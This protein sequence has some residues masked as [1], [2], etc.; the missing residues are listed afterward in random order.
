MAISEGT[1]LWEPSAEW[2]KNANL[3]RYMDWLSEKKGLPFD[4]YTSLWQW[5]VTDLE[6]FWES[7]WE[8]FDIQSKTSYT[9]V[10]EDRR[11]PGAK[12]FVG[13]TLNYAE[14][15]F[16]HRREDETA[17][18]Y[19]SELR[20]LKSLTWRDLEEQVAAFAH[21]L[22]DLGVKKGDRVA[23][24]VANMPEA[25][26]AFLG[27]ASIGAI[28]SSCSPEFGAKSVIDRFKQIEPKVLVAVDGYR[29]NGKDFDRLDTVNAIQK[30]VPT[31]EKTIMIP[32]LHE[33]VSEHTV[34]NMV[35]WQVFLENQPKTQLY[36][37]A[38]PF[39]H[40]LWI[41]FSSG[42]TGI[43][44]AIV[45]GHGGILIEQ[46]KA[47]SLHTDL[48]PEDRFF[49]YTTT[50]WMMW[51]F[52]V[53]GL[54]TGAKIILYDGSP[55]YPDKNALWKLAENTGMTVFGTSAA[56]ITGCMKDQ[57]EPGRHY[58]LS[59]LKAI[60]STGSPLPPNGFQWVYDHVKKD[61]WLA[62]VSGGT[63][64]CSAF[65][66]GAP[67]LPVKTGMIQCRGLGAA[68]YAFDD[69]GKPVVDHVGELVMTEPL[70]SMPLFFWNDPNGSRYRNSYFDVY[71]GI[72]RHGDY[73]KITKDGHCVIYGRSD[74]TINRG[75]VRMGTSE[76]YSAVDSVPEVVDSLIVDIPTENG[77]SDLPLFV[78]L[79]DGVRLDASLENKIKEAI[80]QACSPRHVPNHIV[81]VND[82]PRTINGKK[83]EVPVKKILMG[84]PLEKAA[85]LGS[86][87]N[88]ES[89][90]FFVAYRNAAAT[91]Q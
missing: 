16:R 48:G 45:Q 25:V 37:E 49:W 19:A 56:F 67:I 52:L 71:P 38:V 78:V 31:I 8:Y 51:N 66:L 59:K 7:I 13:A 76:I 23:A 62:S 84:S 12:W 55:S 72:W 61:L 9:K 18:Y 91:E 81:P 40:P 74:A 30:A 29:Y 17:I 75:G 54:L 53:G 26:I 64:V 60:G 70:P 14:H 4:D 28:W 2:K 10:L 39:D 68:V 88:P 41:L 44:K 34:E 86:L 83:L 20:N 87:S 82:I 73:V 3:T 33:T 69:E 80:R 90:K 47:L 6:A 79:K 85:N 27:S 89:L 58:N 1:A 32:Y 46:L 15:I 24:Y 50:G 36:F 11:M 42:T 5:S 21:A 22:K 43:P 57:L 35:E 65:V 77:D 63:D